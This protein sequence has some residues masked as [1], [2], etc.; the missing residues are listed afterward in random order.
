MRTNES[1]KKSKILWYDNPTL[2]LEN[3]N[4]Y[5][6]HNHLSRIE[7][8]NSLARLGIY[9][10]IIILIGGFN[11]KLLSIPILILLLSLFLGKTENFESIDDPDKV[12]QHPTE[13]NPFMNYTLGDQLTKPNRKSA[14]KYDDVKDQISKNFKSKI[15]ADQFD[16]WGNK[17]TDRMFYTM[18]NTKSVNDQTEFAKWCFDLD[19]SCKETGNKCFIERDPET[20]KGRLVKLN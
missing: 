10:T 16:L 3:M 19:N 9:I 17:I 6:P 12:C 14:C 11:S 15:V 20:H 7:K 1:E 4:N 8:I 5:Y 18:P 2:L 13:N